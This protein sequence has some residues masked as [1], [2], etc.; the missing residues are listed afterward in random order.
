MIRCPT[1]LIR[2]N[3][4]RLLGSRKRADACD[5][6]LASCVDSRA[7]SGRIDARLDASSAGR[8]KD[9]G[10][11]FAWIGVG[12]RSTGPLSD[13]ALVQTGF[14]GGDRGETVTELLDPG[15]RLR[16]RYAPALDLLTRLASVYLGG[17][18]AKTIV[19][20]LLTVDP[21][22]LPSIWQLFRL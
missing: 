19:R 20:R 18:T 6:P 5:D 12:L 13:V 16:I 3:R 15:S 17:D 1:D 2:S 4:V 11:G 7:V 9:R 22:R 8:R 21:R 10:L 14:A